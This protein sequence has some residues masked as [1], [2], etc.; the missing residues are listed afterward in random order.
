MRQWL[1]GESWRRN[2]RMGTAGD[3]CIYLMDKP[4][5]MVRENIKTDKVDVDSGSLPGVER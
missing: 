2:V 3:G 1:P 4:E 5:A